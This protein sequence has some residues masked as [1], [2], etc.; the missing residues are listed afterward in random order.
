MLVASCQVCISGNGGSGGRERV[1]QNKPV[2]CYKANIP[3]EL[4]IGDM[5]F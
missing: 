1:K 4:Y 5:E 3:I 2:R